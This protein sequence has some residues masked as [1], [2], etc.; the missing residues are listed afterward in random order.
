[1]FIARFCLHGRQ[2]SVYDIAVVTDDMRYIEYEVVQKQKHLTKYVA[3]RLIDLMASYTI[4]D[5]TTVLMQDTVEHLSPLHLYFKILHQHINFKFETVDLDRATRRVSVQL[6]RA[7][8]Y[9]EVNKK[10]FNKLW[11]KLIKNKSCPWITQCIDNKLQNLSKSNAKRKRM[12]R[13]FAY[14]MVKR[15]K[16]MEIHN[17]CIQNKQHREAIVQQQQETLVVQSD[18]RKDQYFDVSV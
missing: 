3:K 7:K 17:R 1:M 6:L 18:T 2:R 14:Y 8:K 15:R 16:L 9:S 13:F 5:K 11:S 12:L 10:Y 4:D